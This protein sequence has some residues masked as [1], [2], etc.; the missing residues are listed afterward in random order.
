MSK[1]LLREGLLDK[2]FKGVLTVYFGSKLIDKVAKRRAMNDPEVKKAVKA[3]KDEL[4]KF[5]A[6]MAEYE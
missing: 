1:K 4:A 5:D 6:I 2:V 3:F